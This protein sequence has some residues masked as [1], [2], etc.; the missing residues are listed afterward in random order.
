M[1]LWMNS[2]IKMSTLRKIRVD[3]FFYQLGKFIWLP[4]CTVGFWFSRKGF[5]R[6]ADLM[7]C[8]IRRRCG[9]PC[10]GCG[11]TRALYYLFQG[12]FIKSFILNPTVMY[13]ILAYLHFMLLFFYRKHI[14][15]VIAVREI[16]LQY[17]MYIAIGVI[18]IQWSAKLIII[19][20]FL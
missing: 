14:S 16:H 11:G 4:F 5:Y 1:S 6:Y 19:L 17:Y 3:E 13:G 12:E 15:K 2:I 9:L 8:A 20:F 18:L 7:A 10:P